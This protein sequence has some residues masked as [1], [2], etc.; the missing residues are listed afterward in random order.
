M[1]A[2]QSAVRRGVCFAYAFI[3]LNFRVV[4]SVYFLFI[5]IFNISQRDVTLHFSF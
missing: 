5:E 1:T 3:T 2:K 4:Q